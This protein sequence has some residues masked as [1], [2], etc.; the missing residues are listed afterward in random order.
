MPL[1]FFLS[2]VALAGL[3]RHAARHASK[4]NGFGMRVIGWNGISGTL[5]LG[6]MGRERNLVVD[7]EIYE[8]HQG[9]DG[10]DLRNDEAIRYLTPRE[11]ARLQGFPDDFQITERKTTAWR[12][13]ADSVPIPMVEAVARR[14]RETIE[15]AGR[16]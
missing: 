8:A 10:F 5:T 2:K 11:F 14:I 15:S 7:R 12:Q 13:F 9:E 6:G 3:R 4:G 16:W 1:D